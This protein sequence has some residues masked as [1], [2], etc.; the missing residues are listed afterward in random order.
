VDRREQQVGS[1]IGALCGKCGD[2]WHVV[3]ARAAGRIAQVECKQCG[4][5]HRFRPPPGERGAA[6]AGVRRTRT[7]SSSRSRAAS[8][9]VMVEADP[10]RPPRS[11]DPRETYAVGDRLLHASFGEGVVQAVTGPRKIRVQFGSNE[12]LLVHARG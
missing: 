10:S 11:F 5:R 6:S 8:A 1:D 7:A 4:A 2:V 12:K 9:D 3:I